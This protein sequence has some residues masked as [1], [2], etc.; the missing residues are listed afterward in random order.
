M[1]LSG[2]YDLTS[3]EQL[4]AAFGSLYEIPSVALDFTKVTY[5]DSTVISEL[6]RMHNA[7]SASGLERETIV[8]NDRNLLKLFDIL[9][10]SKVFRVV[11]NLDD[12]IRKDGNDV[13]VQYA[14]SFDRERHPE[15]NGSI[16]SASA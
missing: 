10:F 8:V 4:R 12:A 16:K 3:K 9:N 1:M 6:V 2:E 15:R 7:R 14:S 13:V 11:D 5:I